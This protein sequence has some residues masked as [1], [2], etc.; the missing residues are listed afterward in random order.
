MGRHRAHIVN[1]K[2]NEAGIAETTVPAKARMS[3]AIRLRPSKSDYE[4]FVVTTARAM[5]RTASAASAHKPNTRL[6]SL[7]NLGA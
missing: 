3:G 6:L 5:G 4:T 7:L 2:K 1:R